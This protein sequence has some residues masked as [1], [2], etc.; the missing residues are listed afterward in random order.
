VKNRTL[1][2][3]LACG[4]ALSF[5]VAHAW[6][7]RTK[8][9]REQRSISMPSHAVLDERAQPLI[10]S[11]GKVGFV[12]SVTSG[13][14]MA[15]GLNTGK[16]L[17]AISVGESVGPITMVEHGGRRLIAA[18]AS[19]DPRGGHPATVTIVDATSIRNLEIA[20][21]LVLPP[22]A[23]ITPATRALLSADG[24]HCFIASSFDDPTLFSFDVE[25]GRLISRI[26]LPGRPAEIA[27]SER[28]GRRT[29][30]VSSSVSN[31]MLLARFDS[32]GE[33][34]V[35][36]SF[37]PRGDRL[38]ESNNPA[39][40]PDGTTVFIAASEGDRLY[41]LS[42]ET[43]SVLGSAAVS[44]PHR[45]SVTRKGNLDLIAVTRVQNPA[46]GRGGVT[47]FSSNGSV[48]EQVS[49]FEPP[50]GVNF[51]QANNAVFTSDAMTLFV[52]SASGI[53]FA[54][55]LETGE[56]ESY[57][58]IGSELRRVALS[59]K[60]NAIAA[61]RSTPAGDHVVVVNFDVTADDEPDPMAPVIDSLRPSA[62]EQGRL[63]NLRLVVLGRNFSEGAS[64]VVNDVEVAADIARDGAALQTKLP[65]RLFDHVGL[66]SVRIKA[67]NGALSEPRDLAVTR[68]NAPAIEAMD[69][70]EVPGPASPFE[71]TVKA[72]NLRES[73]T[74]FIGD[75]PLTTERVN[76]R[77]LRATVPA[78][79]AGTV[80][81]LAVSVRD[82]AVPDLFSADEELLIFGPRISELKP[83]VEAVVAG[84][85][86]FLLRIRGEN[87]RPGATVELKLNGQTFSPE[88]VRVRNR[89]LIRVNMKE[90]FY[91]EAG[92]MTVVVRNAAGGVSDP[93]QLAINGPQILS[94]EPGKVLAG[95][96]SARVDIRGTNF[97]KR[98]RVFVG[99]DEQAL[100]LDHK[101]VR[102]RNKRR[103]VVSLT[104]DL[105]ALLAKPAE[106]K[107]TVVNPNDADGVPS[108][109]KELE[110]VGPSISEVEVNQTDEGVNRILI[111]G[112]NFRKGATVEFL[113]DGLVV[114]Q[115]TPDKVSGVRV[116]LL[117][118]K[119][120]L[121]GM[122]DYRVR[123]VNPNNVPSD[124]VG[125]RRDTRIAG[126]ED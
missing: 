37:I 125:P 61:V 14:V 80:G 59:E 67:S 92:T 126:T 114:R 65:R 76:E 10:A 47:V 62:V 96:T 57:N 32:A 104:Q 58:A 101:L 15:F 81:K 17:S 106:L 55:S 52:G 82:L 77:K 115:Q 107:F 36:G 48:L 39:F 25:S 54:F 72:A 21:L 113:V 121:D 35:A 99:T 20:S 41:A 56:L 30:A 97:R 9:S 5:A 33:L 70:I 24:K 23:M 22:E 117:I 71:L 122:G 86:R 49:S 84:D 85:K 29:I 102:F 73:S 53:L 4:A 112:A 118:S 51:S 75:R 103:I 87:F 109:Q 108:E 110:I 44:S 7:N 74:I 6:D 120:K 12:S 69:P 64:L 1:V 40:S 91:Q 66:I 45:I 34:S 46:E 11:S 3:V 98:A 42:A 50:D 100:R 13:S 26:E 19:N 68:P 95:V 16:V 78:E 83:N 105:S 93:A 8:L 18:P 79:I 88:A 60:A 31:S 89:R 116:S 43:G 90:K 27:M 111:A 94:F 28:A 119:R 38:G 124:A 2:G 123:V 63:K